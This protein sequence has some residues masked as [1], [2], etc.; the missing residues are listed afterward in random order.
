MKP[1][2]RLTMAQALVRFLSAQRVERDGH[3]HRF[4][5]GC[6]GIFG[7]GNVTGVGQALAEQPELLTYYQARN[8]Q[9][10]V[11]A[12]AAFAKMRNRLAA[13]ACTTSIGPGAPARLPPPSTG[14]RCYSFQGTSL[15]RGA[16]TPFCSSW[17][18]PDVE[19]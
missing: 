14:C 1:A 3:E 4:F 15:H 18:L 12:A 11:H 17:S 13:L 8:E 16:A 6:F 2:V 19:N 5:E 9:G 7:H 10:M